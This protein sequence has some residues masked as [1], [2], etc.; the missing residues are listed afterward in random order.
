MQAVEQ[1]GEERRTASTA[2]ATAA[3]AR[4]VYGCVERVTWR[5]GRGTEQAGRGVVA[6]DGGVR[7]RRNEGIRVDSEGT[8]VG[9]RFARSRG[10]VTR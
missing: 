10:V 9:Q 1:G 5:A 4:S 3:T 8:G 6:I 2:T 7:S